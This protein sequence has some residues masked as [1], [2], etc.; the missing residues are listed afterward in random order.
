MAT[1]TNKEDCIKRHIDYA[2]DTEKGN[3]TNS[4]QMSRVNWMA[5][6]IPAGCKALDVGCNS[7]S[8][9]RLVQAEWHGVDVSLHLVNEANKVMRAQVAEAE[10]LPFPDNEFDVVVLGEILEHVFSPEDV[11]D[12]AVRVSKGTVIGTTPHELGR[13]GTT[14]AAWHPVDTHAEHVRCFTRETLSELLNKYSNEFTIGNLP[15]G[16]K[17]PDFYYFTLTVKDK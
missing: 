6:Q 10:N 1:A 9:A 15:G 17:R 16:T 2:H 11:M 14:R 4:I 3:L 13:W 8:M 5:S 12:E 7:G